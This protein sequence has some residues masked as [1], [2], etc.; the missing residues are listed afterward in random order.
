MS[1]TV[2]LTPCLPKEHF[3]GDAGFLPFRS[4]SLREWKPSWRPEVTEN[5]FLYRHRISRRGLFEF[6]EISESRLKIIQ[7]QLF[8]EIRASLL[9]YGFSFP[10][11]RVVEPL[12]VLDNRDAHSDETRSPFVD[13]E[14]FLIDRK[15]LNLQGQ[16]SLFQ[17]S[18][19]NPL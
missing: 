11:R 7:I 9:G 19:K 17:Y 5:T 2:V 6:F 13:I 18:L 15:R 14:R 16:S 10:E 4:H 12:Q 1:S 8:W 3:S